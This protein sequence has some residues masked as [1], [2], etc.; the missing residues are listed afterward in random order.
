MLGTIQSS[1][2]ATFGAIAPNLHPCLL[3]SLHTHTPQALQLL[4]LYHFLYD[5]FS[6][7]K[8]RSHPIGKGVSKLQNGRSMWL[9]CALADD[10]RSEVG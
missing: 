9:V 4:T 2:G 1:P 10:R 5:Y 7:V 3:L 8:D 6:L